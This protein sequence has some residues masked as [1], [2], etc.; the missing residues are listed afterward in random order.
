MVPRIF[1][2]Q[3]A[4]RPSAMATVAERRFNDADALRQ[5]GINARANGVAYLAGFVIEILLKAQ[6]VKS[7][8]EIARKRQHEVTGN[9]EEIWRLILE[10]ARFGRHAFQAGSIGGS[11]AEKGNEGGMALPGRTQE[12]LFPMD[13]SGQIL[14][15]YNRDG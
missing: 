11:A 14:A 12:G 6:L 1:G 13:D 3:S 8:P 4:L 2:K 10:A 7:F 15:V 5:T 9:E